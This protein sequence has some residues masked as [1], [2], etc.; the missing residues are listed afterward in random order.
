MAQISLSSQNS[1]TGSGSRFT[2]AIEW[3]VLQT[4]ASGAEIK[5]TL[6]TWITSGYT[7]ATID[8]S[9]SGGSQTV[10]SGQWGTIYSTKISAGE[11]AEI[12]SGTFWIYFNSSGVASATISA[13]A[14][15]TNSGSFSGSISGSGS[16]SA[17]APYGAS[18][19]ILGAESVQMGKKLLISLDRDNSGC[20]HT[21]KYT[22]GGATATIS[23]GVGGS[24]TWTV[25]D[26]ASKCNNATSGECTI[27]CTTYLNGSSLGS[28]K[29][30]V[31]LTVPDATTPSSSG[32]EV[33]MG[34]A[35]SI[36][37]KR[38]SGNFTVKLQLEFKNTTVDIASGAIDTASWIP[39]YD[40][41][42][43]IPALTSG[44][45]T[46]KC[47]TMNGTA[48]VGTRTTTIRVIVPENDVTRPVFT[49]DGITLTPVTTLPEAFEGLYMRGK[50]GLKAAFTASSD[51]STI[52][53]YSL[54]IGNQSATGNPAT[55]DL[56]VSEGEV[57]VT[58]KVTDA[59]GFSTSVS[60]T[61]TV[62]PYRNPKV[63]PYTGYSDVI[64]E[65]AKD[66]GELSANGTYLAIKAGKSFS[67][68]R[69]NGVEMN[70]CQLRYRWK[71]NGASAY[72][73]WITLLE[74]GSAETE[75]SLLVGNVVSSLQ[76][77]YLVEIE[78]V[79]ALNGKHTLTFQIMT[80]AVSFVL[81]D[82]PDGAGFG[83]YPEEPHVV[84]IASHMTLLVRGKLM[85]LGN[86]W[87]SIGLA[88]FIGESGYDYGRKETGCFY[89]VTEGRHVHIAFNCMY[90]YAGTAIIVNAT[91]IPEENRPA[92]PVFSLCPANDRQIAC[93][94]V[95]TDGYIRVE[96]IQK[97]TDSVL[98]G[99]ADVTWVDGYLCYWT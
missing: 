14:T 55:I 17:S 45:G 61:I 44:T 63:T 69:L 31:T 87:V 32:S 79:D 12:C 78:A 99:A 66:T 71:P 4:T 64:C 82:G 40:L 54:V 5:V 94:S 34:T 20:T 84:D 75:I 39:G 58:G 91:P 73:D 51:Y 92:R 23:T 47:T 18:T 86:D 22:F 42:K 72:T 93:V 76:K 41:A 70:S 13:T 3:E 67:S 15:I 43:L 81:Y 95:D 88:D 29:A 33:T 62:M 80:E 83:K 49:A 97:A 24:H 2:G 38:N 52:T 90:V 10:A 57:K 21:L 74:T 65:R 50:T 53:E 36:T 16:V 37:C 35:A 77:S 98:T 8:G 28:T 89:L 96:W 1:A 48:E 11:I 56:L 25:P 68:V 27:T 26:L 60:V 9:I 30:T 19:V 46:L 59:R 6:K 85:V 7:Y